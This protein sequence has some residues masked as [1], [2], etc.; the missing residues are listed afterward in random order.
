MEAKK[1]NPFIQPIIW[2]IEGILVGFG[3]ILPGISGGTLLIAFGMYKPI[4]DLLSN[5]FKNI[6]KY[7]WMLGF[8]AIGGVIGFVGLS[9]LAA[10]LMEKN[11]VILTCVFAGFIFG[12]V[13]E[14]M[15]DAIEKEPRNKWSYVSM[16]I[17]FVVM[18]LI[19]SLLKLNTNVTMD[20]GFLAWIFC[21]IVWGLSFIVPGLSSSSLLLF[22]GIYQPMLDGISKLNFGVVIPL[23]I[24]AL[25]CVLLLSKL[26]NKLF[27]KYHGISSHVIVG[28]VIATTIM[29]LPSFETKF[30]DIMFY[31]LTIISSGCVSFFFTRVC[32]K[33]KEKNS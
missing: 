22:F 21:G 23:I 1:K 31:I 3:A 24:S 30:L 10:Y 27:N 29:I 33:I 16:A 4:I 28:I 9:G 6:K 15:E 17:G 18:I 20:P 13:P 25:L 7:I 19:L 14:L 32:K 8:F 5:P 12:T 2:I 11:T 26:I